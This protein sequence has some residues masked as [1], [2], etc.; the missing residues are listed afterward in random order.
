MRAYSITKFQIR[1]IHTLKNLLGIDD[2]TYRDM[3]RSFDVSSSKNLTYTEAKILLEILEDNA[4]KANLWVKRGMK[5]DDPARAS[6]MATGAQRRMIEGLWREI[7]YKDTD[8]FAKQSLRNFL[9]KK[10]NVEDTAFLSKAKAI[11]AIQAI[12]KIK[13]KSTGAA[14]TV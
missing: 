14:A 8:S 1:K 4:E 13:Q 2:N 6:F 5:Y 7:S 3:L 11:K 12:T 10:F 9:K